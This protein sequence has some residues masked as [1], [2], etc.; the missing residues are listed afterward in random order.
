MAVEPHLEMRLAPVSGPAQ[1]SECKVD[2]RLSRLANGMAVLTSPMP[3]MYSASI[4]VFVRVGSRYELAEES[5]TAHLVEHMMFKGT[6]K[7]PSAEALTEPIERAGGSI[8]AS[9][10]KE[11]TVYWARVRADDLGIALDV[12]ADMLLNSL[13]LEAE[14]E[15]ERR[16]ILE[17][18]AMSTDSPQEWVHTLVDECCWP[19]T[20]IGRDIAGSRKSV[21][22]L[23]RSGVLAFRARY[24]LPSNVLVSIAGAIEH[25][26]AFGLVKSYFGNWTVS[27]VESQPPVIPIEYKAAPPSVSYTVRRTEQVSLCI[28][29][30]GVPRLS[31]DRYAFELLVSMLGGS[32]SSRLFLEIRERRA[33]AYDVH[34]YG[35]SVS[36]TGA[37]V[38]FAAVDPT[39]CRAVVDEVLSQLRQLR[40]DSVSIDELQKAKDSAKGRLLLGLEDTQSVSGWIGA[41][42]ALNGEVRQP[43]QVLASIDEV[44]LDDVQ[45]IARS[46]FRAEYLKLVA[47]GP[48]S[49]M[50]NIGTR[51][52]L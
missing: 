25:D 17:E 35:N 26:D 46:C 16:V 38:T 8:N 42:H 36:D 28:A 41:Q 43:E 45:R 20:S 50:T 1:D 19:G 52:E 12:L 39:N 14:V 33:L 6:E 18:L 24:Y 13:F 10:D 48:K 30:L 7:R 32:A 5:G 47:L 22:G 29:T 3:A 51:F 21:S 34:S 44:T 9:T 37:L 4:S 2:V 40:A 11:L 49:G 31:T 27:D 15:K 23:T